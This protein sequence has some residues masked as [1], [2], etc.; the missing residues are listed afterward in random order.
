MAKRQDSSRVFQR[1]S[2]VSLKKCMFDLGCIVMF[3][4]FL[5]GACHYRELYQPFKIKNK[6]QI[7]CR[8]FCFTRQGS[9]AV[10]AEW[11]D[12]ANGSRPGL[13]SDERVRVSRP[14]CGLPLQACKPVHPASHNEAAECVLPEEVI[15]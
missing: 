5:S 3:L 8:L 14:F 7:A 13:R 10:S 1:G 11:R 2:N 6:R 12:G 4:R 15:R 9:R